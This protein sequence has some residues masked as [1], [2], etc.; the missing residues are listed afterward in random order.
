[1]FAHNKQMFGSSFPECVPF[2]EIRSTAAAF[3]RCQFFLHMVMQWCRLTHLAIAY[4]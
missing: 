1:M 2:P 3:L 4:R